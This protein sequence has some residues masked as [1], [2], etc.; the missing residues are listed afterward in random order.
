MNQKPSYEELERRVTELEQQIDRYQAE[1]FQ[2]PP[3]TLSALMEAFLYIPRCSTFEDAARHIFDHCKRLTGALSGYVALVSE[4]GRE[5]EM[6]F[7]DAGGLPCDVDP[8]L[9]MPIRG[10]REVVYKTGAP[11]RDN[12]FSE[13]PWMAFVPKGH[14]RLDNVLFAPLTI[15][16]KPVGVMGLANKPGGFTQQDIQISKIMGDLAALALSYARSQSR[17]KSSEAQF[18]TIYEN[19]AVGIAQVTTGGKFKQVNAK[20]ADITGYSEEELTGMSVNE[21]T[22]PADQEKEGNLI[23]RV[24]KGEIDGFEIEKRYIHKN[25]RLV[26]IEL[27]SNVVRDEKNHIL[28]AIASV[29]DITKRKLAETALRQ[30]EEKYRTLYDDAPVGYFEY[31]LEGNI[32]Q[33]NQTHLNLLGYSAEE[34]I[35]Q[36]CWHFIV[37]DVAREQ[38]MAKLS[39]TM[40]PAAGLERTYRRKDGTTFPV[41]FEDRLLRNEDKTITGIRTAIQDITRIK[42]ADMEREKLQ[43]QLHQAQKLESIGSL[44]G[45]IAHDF[46]NLLFPIVGLSEMMMDD[47]PPESME[48]QNIQEIFNAGS[49]GRELIQQILSF[50]RQSKHLLIPVHI[51]KVLKE[52][53]KLCRATIPADIPITR[54]IQTDCGPVM[55][56]PTQIHQIAMNLITNAYHAVEPR[57][58][59]ISVSLKEIDF[60]DRADTPDHPA[61]GRYAKLSVS[62][63]G[64]GIDPVVLD[65]IFDPYFTTKKKGRGTGLG[66]STVYGIVKAHGGEIRVDSAA[67]KGSDFHVYLPVIEKTLEDFPEKPYHPLPTGTEHIL[68]VDDESPIVLMERQ[69]LERLGYRITCFTGSRE[70]LAAFRA[71]PSGFDLVLTDMNM[72]NTNGMQLAEQLKDIRSDIPIVICTGFS[73]RIKK[74]KAAA[75]G[76]KGFLM[77]PVAKSDLAEMVR[78]VLDQKTDVQK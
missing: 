78:N 46:N 14:V 74:E 10:L 23:A 3:E 54:D 56:D 57:G 32:T 65:K 18:R 34:M 19:T 48:H 25:G 31:D 36:P 67:G 52:V 70:A 5:N 30:S 1:R 68:L 44:A 6:L 20:F 41:L 26:W 15:G 47:F 73:E 55:A 71:D 66:L 12:D 40:P 16:N 11:A 29:I 51:Q 9:P 4:N 45:G 33:V 60:K 37:D 2:Y 28:Y 77:K 53:L 39:G 8:N 22:Y 58:G 21:I 43:S 38:I 49:R 61:S 13:S 59:T 72:P 50:S 63:T 62:D 64:T 69:M 42:K 27:Y 17:L 24:L 75:I 7:L 76:I 35:G